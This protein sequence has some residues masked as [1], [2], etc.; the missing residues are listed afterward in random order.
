MND[1]DEKKKQGIIKSYHIIII[2]DLKLNPLQ[3]KQQRIYLCI[4]DVSSSR[5][6]QLYKS[7][8]KCPSMHR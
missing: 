5:R 3:Y 2:I 7:M 6:D 4:K 8:T 1:G